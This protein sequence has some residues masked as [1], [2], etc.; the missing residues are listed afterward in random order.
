MFTKLLLCDL[1][2]LSDLL[3]TRPQTTTRK[4]SSPNGAQKMFATTLSQLTETPAS[5]SVETPSARAFSED[6]LELPAH[7]FTQVTYKSEA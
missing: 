4:D 5:R 6:P 3:H 1:D 7:N 2:Q